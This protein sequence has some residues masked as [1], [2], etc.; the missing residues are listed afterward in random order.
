[1]FDITSRGATVTVD[2]T[3]FTADIIAKLQ[4]YGIRQKIAD[5]A[6][7]AAKVVKEANPSLEG[8]TLDKAVTEQTQAMMDK[9][10][11]ALLKGEWSSRVAGEGVSELVRVQRSVMRSAVKVKLGAK[12]PKWTAFT[13]LDD[14]EQ[15]KKLDAM[16]EANKDKLA[17]AV[18]EEMARREAARK[19]KGKLAD[20]LDI[21]L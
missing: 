3:K 15:N 2:P 21:E 17:P 14:A 11:D 9:A 19:A 12:S 20:G 8:E 1:M 18:K 13:G 5:A 7:S 6:S 4:E 16:F 10:L